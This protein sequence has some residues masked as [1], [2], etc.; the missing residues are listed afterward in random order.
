MTVFYCIFHYVWA[1]NVK[2]RGVAASQENRQ[3]SKPNLLSLSVVDMG[4]C[5]AL[6][7]HRQGHEILAGDAAGGDLDRHVVADMH[8]RRTI[9]WPLANVPT[10][11]TCCV[12]A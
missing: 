9:L 10:L 7:M 1:G 5:A 3:R 11:R 2:R 12:K 8:T 4:G 6:A